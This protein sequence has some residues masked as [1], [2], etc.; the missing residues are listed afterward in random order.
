[1]MKH[2]SLSTDSI[3]PTSLIKSISDNSCGAV[4]TFFGITRADSNGNT[5]LHLYYEAHEP[6]AIRVMSDIADECQSTWPALKNLA[7]VHRL[8]VVPAG[9]ISLGI[10][11]S[12]PHR[13]DALEA[14]R[15]ILDAVKSRVPIW[16]KEVYAN[17]SGSCWKRN[18]ECFWTAKDT[19]SGSCSTSATA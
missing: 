11:A 10:A 13:S 9:E 19:D 5:V 16:K 12:S 8:G 17:R 4:V 1:M 2:L 18:P 6:M 7:I 14:V 3:D 15:F